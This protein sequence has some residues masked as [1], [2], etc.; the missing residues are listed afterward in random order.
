MLRKY[1]EIGFICQ[2]LLKGKKIIKI[3]IRK[4]FAYGNKNKI[5]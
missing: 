4:T 3:P 1:V 5:N 2:A